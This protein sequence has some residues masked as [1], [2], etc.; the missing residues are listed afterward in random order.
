MSWIETL[1]SGRYRASL[2]LPGRRPA[3]TVVRPQADAKAFLASASP[4]RWEWRDPLRLVALPVV[5]LPRSATVVVE[6]FQSDF[7]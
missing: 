7:D 5:R 1:P 6:G 4:A 2:P 3:L